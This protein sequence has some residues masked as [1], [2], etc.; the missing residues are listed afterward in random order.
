MKTIVIAAVLAA[1]VSVSAQAGGYKHPPVHTTPPPVATSN[2]NENTNSNVV[3]NQNKQAQVQG[4]HQSAVAGAISDSNS[5][6]KNS[7]NNTGTSDAAAVSNVNVEGDQQVRQAPAVG[8]GSFAIQG[9]SA[10]GN[11][12][13]SNTH[14][15]AF[16]GFGYTPAE[17]YAF[18]LAQSYQAVGQSKTACEVLNSTDSAKRAVKRGVKLPDCGTAVVVE[19]TTDESVAVYPVPD[20][21]TKAE[22]DK[23]VDTVFRK[24]VN[25]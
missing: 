20:T 7:G 2:K 22:I 3:K 8:Q 17:C 10:A 16:L 6:V 21:Y 23:K 12:G 15:S 13:G 5:S 9:C 24:S 4:Q 25:K 11:G 1:F 14:G 19:K 18:L